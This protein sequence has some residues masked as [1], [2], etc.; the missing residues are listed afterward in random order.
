MR[1]ELGPRPGL[2]VVVVV[3]DQ[4]SPDDV[5]ALTAAGLEALIS[6]RD[7]LLELAARFGVVVFDE[8]DGAVHASETVVI[9]EAGVVRE[10]WPGLESWSGADL[11][12]RV[13]ALMP[14]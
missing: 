8:P 13:A 10:R 12:E 14:G 9:D 6:P 3:L 5:E 4:G 7:E 2:R 1:R 11:L